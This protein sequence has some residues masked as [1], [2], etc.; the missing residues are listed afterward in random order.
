MSLRD[1][2]LKAGLASA[3]QAKKLDSAARK[4]GHQQKKDKA[5]AIEA[6]ARQAEVRRQLEAEAA[7]KREADR[8]LN[9]ERE[10]EKQRREQAI[11][12]RQ[13]IDSH[14]LNEAEAEIH[15]NFLDR[16]GHWIR[17]I[18]VTAPQRQGLATGRLAIVRGDRHEFDFALIARETALKLAE[19]TPER[20]RVLHPEGDGLEVETEAVEGR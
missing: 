8:R 5:L 18:R 15:Y 19:F 16:D 7:G 4:Q 20:L 2:L 13:L 14:R 17:A 11:R 12:T 1:E 9:L 3:D 6:A 10:A